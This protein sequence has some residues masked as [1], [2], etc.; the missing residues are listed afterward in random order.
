MAHLV[1][2][3][4]TRQ[5]LNAWSSG[6]KLEVLSF[7][8]WRAGSDLQ[9]SVSGLLR[10]LL[11]QLCGFQPAI[12][13]LIASRLLS[14]PGKVPTWTEKA[15]LEHISKAI[16]L[17]KRQHY[18]CVF[19]DGLDEYTGSYD[20]L[21][22]CIEHLQDFRYVKFCVSSRPEVELA[23]RFLN[24]KQLRLQDLNR[25][26]IEIFIERSFKKAKLNKQQ[27]SKRLIRDIAL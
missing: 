18:L 27:H 9:K 8:F 6:H 15:L 24:S 7:F 20:D 14:P 11:Y 26:D 16:K 2:D 4:R 3:R 10:T 1:R 21:L 19:I 22:D 23:Y 12:L 17:S 5:E 13:A 25:N